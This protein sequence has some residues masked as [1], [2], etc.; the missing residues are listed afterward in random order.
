M[1]RF[2]LDELKIDRSFLI[3]SN[4]DSDAI[5]AAIIALGHSLR[6]KVV[7]EGVEEET[8]LE[9]LRACRCDE[10]QGFYFSKPIP[11][12]AFE[13]LMRPEG[14]RP[15]MKAD[16]VQRW[17]E[18]H[19][20]RQGEVAGGVVLSQNATGESLLIADWPQAG[21]LSAGLTTVAREAVRR[22]KSLVLVP[23]VVQQEAGHARVVAVPLRSGDKIVGAA[24]LAVRSNDP[25]VAKAILEELERVGSS[26]AE[27]P[28]AQAADTQ[29]IAPEKLL[30]LQEIIADGADLP[31]AALKLANH[32]AREYQ[33]DRVSVGLIQGGAMKIAAVSNGAA[34]DDR[35]DLV[36]CIVDA[37]AEAAD[38]KATRAVSRWLAGDAAHCACSPAAGGACRYRVV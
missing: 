22:A 35:Q 38:Q 12:E 25:N 7:A 2:P 16:A 9:F 21:P 10:Y 8:Q 37:M 13:M 4:E 32:L 5:A 17:L 29:A 15:I 6:L 36:R 26:L 19:C 1:R 27:L 31:T 23:A 33:F 14:K 11:A 3:E 20:Q 18:G 24:A 34:V 30:K 28:S